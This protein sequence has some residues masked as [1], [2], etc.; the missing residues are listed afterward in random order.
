MVF[1]QT[2][3][4]AQELNV[5]VDEELWEELCEYTEQGSLKRLRNREVLMAIA[6]IIPAHIHNDFM[7][8]VHELEGLLNRGLH[9]S[10]AEEY[11][12]NIGIWASLHLDVFHLSD[13]ELEDLSPVITDVRNPLYNVYS[14]LYWRHEIPVN[15]DY[16]IQEI[17]KCMADA[18]HKDINT[19]IKSK[20]V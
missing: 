19:W 9:M 1:E 10:Y 12:I 18:R 16:L 11:V 4:Q 8:A 7:S 3:G 20:E 5:G 14:A 2:Q 6:D 15:E 17:L 13:N